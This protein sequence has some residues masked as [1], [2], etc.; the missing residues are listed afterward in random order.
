MAKRAKK[1]KAA[2]QAVEA[3]VGVPASGRP[4][5]LEWVEAGSLEENPNNW[6]LHPEGQMQ[7][8]KDVLGDDQVGWAGALLYNERTKRLIDGHGR[9]KAVSPETLVPVLIG[10]WSEEAEKKILLTLD[11]LAGMAGV[12][13]ESLR[14][15][16][17]D[18]QLSGDE[19]AGLSESLEELLAE[20]EKIGEEE[21]GGEAP[22]GGE[23]G[24]SGEGIGEKYE[25]VVSCRNEKEQRKVFERLSK[26]GMSCRVLTI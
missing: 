20:A 16:M 8:L 5:R 3:P 12:D 4:L 11:P 17:E 25:V 2:A 9:K 21:A 22:K 13:S 14:A 18:V 19:L 23:G 26:E 7:A 15:L 10:S 6:R 24:G 1:D